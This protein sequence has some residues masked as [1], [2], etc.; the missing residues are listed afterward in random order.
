M[1]DEQ[2]RV[3]QHGGVPDIVRHGRV[4]GHGAEWRPDRRSPPRSRTA[5]T[6]RSASAARHAAQ[7]G[8]LH[9]GVA[10]RSRA[11]PRRGG[12]TRAA[13][14]RP[15]RGPV[16]RAAGLRTSR[17]RAPRRGR[18]AGAGRRRARGRPAV[19]RSA[20]DASGARPAATR[21]GFSPSTGPAMPIGV[22]RAV[23]Q[24]LPV[25]RVDQRHRRPAQA[26]GAAE[27]VGEHVVHDHHVGRAGVGRGDDVGGA[28]QPTLGRAGE[29]HARVGQ[30]PGQARRA[31]RPRPHARRPAAVRPGRGT[32]PRSPR[33][34]TSRAGRTAPRPASSQGA[35]SRLDA[36]SRTIYNQVVMQQ[37]G[38]AHVATVQAH[39]P[40]PVPPSDAQ[41]DATFA[42]LA[43]RPRA[44]SSRAPG[45]G[46]GV[47]DGAGRALR[48]EPAGHL[49]AP[50][51]AQALRLDSARPRRPAPTLPARGQRHARAATDWLDGYRRYWDESYRQPRRRARRHGTRGPPTRRRPASPKRVAMAPPPGGA[52]RE[53]P[54]TSGS[55]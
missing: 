26:L 31:P 1:G 35:A 33:R 16:P 42:A 25:Q 9:P 6:G 24:Q 37:V 20:C 45:A 8:H 47:G 46:R 55:R 54:R 18:R 50:Q 32:G 41:L 13:E 10:G 11:T 23:G 14:P 3:R 36:G 30:P 19:S 38:Y 53:P 2:V 15:R 5:R 21:P 49:Q 7:H 12:R 27:G 44:P 43:D 40:A 17:W 48:H 34:P 22:G 52:T 51:G 28:R 39:D 29:V 4:R